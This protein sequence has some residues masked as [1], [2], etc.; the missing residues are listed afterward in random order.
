M[1]PKRAVVSAW[2]YPQTPMYDRSVIEK[3]FEDKYVPEPNTGCWLWTGTTAGYGY[4]SLRISPAR[5]WPAHRV[6]YLL[7][8][9]HMQEGLVIDHLCRNRGCVNPEHLELVTHAVNILR[10]VGAGANFERRTH[11]G[12]G[13]LL[14]E[15]NV[16]KNLADK[17]RR[18]LICRRAADIL[19]GSGS[20]RKKKG[21]QCE[22]V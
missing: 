7:H 10:G 8:K 17:R 6:S 1:N 5:M 18:C 12:R 15:D 2:A 3:R 19:R 22:S 4:G 21:F 11:C 14:S 13:H 9:G 20:K 16:A